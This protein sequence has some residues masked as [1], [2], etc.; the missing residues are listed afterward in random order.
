MKQVRPKKNLGQHFLTDLSI[1]KRIADTVDVCPD[2]PVLEVGPGMGVMTQFLVEKP[3]PFKVVEID[4]E[5]VAYLNEHFPKLREN[6]L[7]EDFL[8]MDLRQVFGGQQFVLTGNYPYDISSQIFFKMLDNRDIIPC[9]TGMIQHEVAVRMASQPGNKQYGILSVLIQ[10]WYNVEYLFTVEPTVF[11]PPP[12]VMSAVIRMT[13]NEV[14]H[15]GCDEQLFKRVV[16]TVFNQRSKMLRVSLR[17]RFNAQHPTSDAF[18]QQDIMTR[19]PEQLSIP[20]FVELTNIVQ[21]ELG[22]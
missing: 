20:Q 1:A 10:A 15:L 4:R 3:R 2:L 19:R 18:F 17:Q 21:N 12:K 9:C 7:G 22:E 11:N 8:R 14:Q 6:I 5:S 13:R 16:K